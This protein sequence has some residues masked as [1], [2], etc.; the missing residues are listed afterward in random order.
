MGALRKPSIF[1]LKG[2]SS[3]SLTYGGQNSWGTERGR[4]IQLRRDRGKDRVDLR[5]DALHGRDNGESYAS[6]NNRILDGGRGV[7]VL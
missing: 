1:S 3:V 2:S 4:L 5:A 7:L 6:S